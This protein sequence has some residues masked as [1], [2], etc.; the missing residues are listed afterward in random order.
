[1][2]INSEGFM[3]KKMIEDLNI[4]GK[5]V[6][7]RVDFNVPFSENGE[8]RDDT[9]IQSTLPSIEYILNHG[10]SLILMSH[11]G[12]PDG[13][14]IPEF[15]MKPIAKR[16]SRLL[17]RP[18]EFIDDCIGEKVEDRVS[19]LKPGEILLLENLRYYKAEEKP[20]TDPTFAESLAKLGDCFVQEAFGT[21]HRKHSS[22]YYVPKKFGENSVAGYLMQRE[23]DF[24]GR[25]VLDPKR[26]FYA[27]LGGAK[28]STKIGVIRTMMNRVDGLILGGAMVFTF[29]KAE[30][31][32]IGNSLCEDELLDEARLIMAE[33][34]KKRIALILPEDIVIADSFSASAKRKIISIDEGIPDGWMGLDIGPR[35]IKKIINTIEQAA[36]ILWNG[37]LG[38]FELAPFAEGTFAIARA[39]ADSNALTVV[40]GGDSV[41]A[42][43]QMGIGEEFTHL[44]TGG[45]ASLEFLEY[46]TLPGIEAIADGLV[47]H[48]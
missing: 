6:L 24:L 7:M 10:G 29:F 14:K 17:N 28:A 36:T 8:I 32:S 5:K 45:G 25:A 27:I 18:V 15:S 47:S 4:E 3:N 37:P 11:L 21:A 19:H 30:G 41:A 34:K 20:E 33:A 23:I 48:R 44:S 35:S 42:I 39:M 13:K 9:R 38:A 2:R 22:T 12:R 31:I 46:G 26:P 16:L 1:M 43:Q 40:G